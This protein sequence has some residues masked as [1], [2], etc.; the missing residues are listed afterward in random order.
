MG[1]AAMIAH[2]FIIILYALNYPPIHRRGKLD[3]YV[4][5]GDFVMLWILW[6]PVFSGI[7]A[8]KMMPRT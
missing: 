2:S 5:T 4:A 6:E 3:L 1:R 8:P 7:T